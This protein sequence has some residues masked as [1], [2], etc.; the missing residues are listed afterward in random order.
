MKLRES[1]GEA[2]RFCL[3][4]GFATALHYGI[5][6]I[7]APRIEVHVAYTLGY[8]VSFLANFFLTAYFTFRTTPSWAKLV[9]MAGA[10]AV[11]YL[12]HILLL[13]LFL[14]V[15]VP[16]E[17]APV[18]VYAVAVPVNLLLVR[19]VFKRKG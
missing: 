8:V 16:K 10:H 6:L 17:W 13:S 2:F 9:G 12:L 3:V 18:P 19:F 7:L 4:G 14:A 1:A 5:Y 11:N 15:G